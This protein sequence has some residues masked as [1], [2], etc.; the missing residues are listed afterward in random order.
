M[1][2]TLT[3][4]A[5]SPNALKYEYNYDGV[6]SQDIT[7]DQATLIADA[8]VGPLN[9]LLAGVT[10]DN[11]WLA[12]PDNAD[13]GLYVT[14]TAG[15]GPTNWVAADIIVSGQDRVLRAS[16]TTLVA[17]RGYVELRF[18]HTLTR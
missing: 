9:D 1:A 17:T 4:K 10:T 15:S 13:L 7:I 18:H 8:P 16:S 6:A 3:L 11:D 12:L 2:A 5:A 14:T